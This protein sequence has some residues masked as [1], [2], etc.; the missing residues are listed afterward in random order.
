MSEAHTGRREDYSIWQSL[1]GRKLIMHKHGSRLFCVAVLAAT[2][3]GCAAIEQAR[4]AEAQRDLTIAR[5][6]CGQR[7]T[8][9][10]SG[11]AACVETQLAVISDQ[12]RRALADLA[13][14]TQVPSYGSSGRLCVPT[15]AEA[16]II[17]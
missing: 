11:F 6:S 13:A 10:T 9:G 5:E 12:R 4:Q 2:L 15:A 17:C 3:S 8:D 16:G 1:S 7:F 14:P